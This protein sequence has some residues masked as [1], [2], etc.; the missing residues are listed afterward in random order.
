MFPT[1]PTSGPSPRLA[2]DPEVIGPGVIVGPET[3]VV[4]LG[5]VG[6][7]VVTRPEVVAG[8]GTVVLFAGIAP[9]A[10]AGRAVADGSVATDG[11]GVAAGPADG[12]VKA[13]GPD[14]VVGLT[15]EVGPLP[16]GLFCTGPFCAGLPCMGTLCGGL[17]CAGSLWTDVGP[18][19]VAAPGLVVGKTVVGLA[20]WFGPAA[21]SGVACGAGPVVTTESVGVPIDEGPGTVVGL[22]VAGGEGM[23]PVDA[24]PGAAGPTFVGPLFVGALFI[25]QWSLARWSLARC[26][27]PGRR[28][29]LRPC[30]SD[31][32]AKLDRC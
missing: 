5:A 25:G 10:V 2:A 28:R 27:L 15:V 19:F 17:L 12:L 20:V 7:E 22:E 24:G 1:G 6:P 14:G 8:P 30:A 32:R 4:G 18:V 31:R 29:Y 16:A 26:S 3:V 9:V 23:F 21:T 13:A 11:P